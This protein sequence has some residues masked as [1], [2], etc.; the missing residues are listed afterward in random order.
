MSQTFAVPTVVAAGLP[1]PAPLRALCWVAGG[2]RIG[3]GHVMRS[4]ELARTLAQRGLSI[5]GF[6]CNDDAASRAAIRAAG[7]ACWPD[8]DGAAPAADVLLVD[9]PAG[10]DAAVQAFVAGRPGLR[11]AALDDFDMEG[12]RAELVVNLINH[13]PTL[14]RPQSARVHYHEGPAYAII[15]GEFVAARERPRRFPASA[16]EVVV[17]FGGADPANHTGRVLDALAEHPLDGVTVRLVIGPAFKGAADTAAR[18][19]SLGVTVLERV[20]DL[21]PHF[22]AADLAVSGGGTTMLELACVGTPTLVLPQNA[23]EARFAASLAA[24]GAVCLSEPS[25][26]PR[27][28]PALIHDAAARRRLHA[29]ARASVDGLGCRRIADLLVGTFGCLASCP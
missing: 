24:R 11:L 21:A 13:H 22:A 7:Y 1:P 4:L 26:L 15:R 17:C 19:R 27:D 28:L 12:G 23:A 3:L 14:R 29:A 8:G 25:A 16:R 5:V 20:A 6:L 9:R 2:P 10:V 18:A